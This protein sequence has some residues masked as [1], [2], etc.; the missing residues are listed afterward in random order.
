VKTLLGKTSSTLHL[1]HHPYPQPALDAQ[2]RRQQTEDGRST[3]EPLRAWLYRRRKPQVH[4]KRHRTAPHRLPLPAV[5]LRYGK[6][7][8][9]G[10]FS[11][12][13]YDLPVFA[14]DRGGFRT[15]RVVVCGI[16]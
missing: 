12:A 8:P 11:L 15:G 13:G 7:G 16:L 14:V 6:P 1:P 4:R 3:H 2:L 10:Y 5:R 9:F